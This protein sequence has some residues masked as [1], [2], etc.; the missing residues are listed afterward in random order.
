MEQVFSSPTDLAPA[1]VYLLQRRDRLRFKIGWALNPVE[2]VRAFPEF[3]RL[4]LDLNASR[5]LWLPSAARARAIEHAMHR[6]LAPFKSPP[7]HQADGHSEWFSGSGTVAALSLLAR[8]PHAPGQ[9]PPTLAPL[10]DH[11]SP[12]PESAGLDDT[13]NAVED[14]LQRLRAC[15]AVRLLPGDPQRLVVESFKTRVQGALDDLRTAALDAELYTCRQGAALRPLVRL[16][17]YQ[18]D[19]LVLTLTP[20]SVIR[21][22]PDG[23]DVAL[24]M[25]ASLARLSRADERLVRER[26]A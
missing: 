19:D 11:A 9:R 12:V 24:Q 25:Q 6:A 10:L 16:M 15:T 21:R 22:W 23:G 14:V 8:M 3:G 4:Q 18:G 5:V 2:R 13:W 17:E 26:A 20:F 1:A 7:P